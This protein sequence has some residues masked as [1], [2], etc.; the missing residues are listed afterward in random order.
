MARQKIIVTGASGQLGNELRE[1]SKVFGEFEFFFLTRQE[2]SIQDKS[3]VMNFF[4][5]TRPGYC[6]NCAAYTAVDKAESEQEEA[7]LING[8]STGTLAEACKSVN[9]KFIHVSTDYVF[10]GN[11]TR[12][13]R[14]DDPVDPVNLYGAS[15]QEGE[16]LAQLH[17]P[18]SIII[19]TS[20]VYSEFGNN[21]LKT[22]LRLM[23]DRPSLQVVNDQVGS[24]TYA[25]DLAEAILYIIRSGTWV[26]GI[27][28][29]SNEGIISWFDFA[30]AI[31]KAINSPCQVNPIPSSQF[32][33]KAK[34]PAYSAMDKTK[35]KDIFHLQIPG[36]KESMERCLGKISARN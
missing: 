2:L 31:G 36:W 11:G 13:Y 19:R 8:E 10:N 7:F 16:V 27:Y 9:A 32:P 6:I 1:A 12:P 4:Q 33:T 35:I 15:K 26:P 14:E 30:T 28:H 22:M 21:F 29:Y 17:N 5:E 18:D 3:L 23:K 34:R 24:P 25:A 20:W